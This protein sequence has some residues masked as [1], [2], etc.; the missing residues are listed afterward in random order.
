MCCGS[1]CFALLLALLI[2]VKLFGHTTEVESRGNIRECVVRNVMD[3]NDRR[4]SRSKFS[5][6]VLFLAISGLCNTSA[7]LGVPSPIVVPPSQYLYVYLQSRL[8]GMYHPY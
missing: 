5:L 3:C 6:A 7:A 8:P 4:Q 1:I 2:F